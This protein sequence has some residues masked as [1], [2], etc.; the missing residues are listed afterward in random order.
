MDYNCPHRKNC[1]HIRCA[2]H[3][4]SLENNVDNNPV[5]ESCEWYV[6]YLFKLERRE[7][8]NEIEKN[9]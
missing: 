5:H 6:K 9:G 7:K 1:E 4:E 3:I 8:I 2:H